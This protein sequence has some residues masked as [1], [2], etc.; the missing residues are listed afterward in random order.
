MRSADIE[1]VCGHCGQS[2]A[3]DSHAAGV[4]VD[5][6][7]CSRPIAVP[8]TE[9]TGAALEPCGEAEAGDQALAE[10]R[11]LHEA[12]SELIGKLHA[13]GAVREAALQDERRRRRRA[14][15]QVSETRA[16]LSEA[17]EQLAEA[18]GQIESLNARQAAAAGE[19]QRLRRLL[20]EDTAE[21]ERQAIRGKLAAAE[22]ECGRLTEALRRVEGELAAERCGGQRLAAVVRELGRRVNE[23]VVFE[24]WRGDRDLA[25]E[26]EVL[27][28]IAARQSGQIRLQHRELVRLRRARLA[29][30]IVYGIFALGLVGLGYVA[31]QLLPGVEWSW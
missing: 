16:A 4:A 14:E 29:L 31:L 11:A 2:I 13:A 24:P 7:A 10:A 20:R 15:A 1:F 3:A 25:R 12:A 23:A 30:R 9:R 17:L 19:K 5:C 27:R 26:V 28:G 21:G 18:G 22:A 8:Y 6:P